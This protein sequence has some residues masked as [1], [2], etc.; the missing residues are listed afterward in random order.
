[1]MITI[2]DAIVGIILILGI[3]GMWKMFDKII[4]PWI[5]NKRTED[6]EKN[7]KWI[8]SKLQNTYYGFN[9]MDI[10][11]VNSPFG[12]LPRFR[13]NK[14]QNKLQLLI[15]EDTSTNDIDNIAQL[16]LAGKLKIKYGLWYP[17]K[18]TYWLAILNFMLDGGDIQQMDAK[19]EKDKK[20]IDD[21]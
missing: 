15:A 13:I 16:A 17:D 20:P 21:F 3:C 8:T 19:I 11:T 14:K 2:Y 18:P 10:V 6:I 9:D 4:F 5:V 1:M 7:P 12:M